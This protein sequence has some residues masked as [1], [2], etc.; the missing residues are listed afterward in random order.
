LGSALVGTKAKTGV[1]SLTTMLYNI[2]IVLYI[3]ISKLAV[4]DCVIVHLKVMIEQ[5]FCCV[6]SVL[7]YP[8]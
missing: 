6:F 2:I 1:C 4:K 8:E 5:V 7:V 3:I